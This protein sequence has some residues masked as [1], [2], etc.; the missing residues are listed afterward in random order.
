MPEAGMTKPY[1][2]CRRTCYIDVVD[3]RRSDLKEYQMLIHS[4][5][6]KPTPV[7][8]ILNHT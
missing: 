5:Y 6:T 3:K 2:G 8:L 4:L 7:Y 1:V